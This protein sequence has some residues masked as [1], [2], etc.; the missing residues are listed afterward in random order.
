MNVVGRINLDIYRAVM[1]DIV[2]DEVIITDERIAH[3][4]ER[5]PGDYEILM[6]YFEYIIDA[7]DFIGI[8]TRPNTA[9]LFKKIDDI[10]GKLVLRLHVKGDPEEYRNS[11]ITGMV[12]DEQTWKRLT[13]DKKVLYKRE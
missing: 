5:H 1:P 13:K 2:T 12:I 9:V 4:Q 3:I 11:I 6:P 8:S 10:Y 7:P